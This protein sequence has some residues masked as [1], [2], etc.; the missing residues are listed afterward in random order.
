MVETEVILDAG[1]EL[2]R[3]SAQAHIRKRD[4]P[5]SSSAGKQGFLNYGVTKVQVR[6]NKNERAGFENPAR[7]TV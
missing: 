3:K 7:E 4:A 1:I 6:P 5:D 2:G